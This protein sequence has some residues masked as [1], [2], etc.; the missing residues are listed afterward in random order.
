MYYFSLI[1]TYF[2][3]SF[4]VSSLFLFNKTHLISTLFSPIFTHPCY[5]HSLYFSPLYQTD[6]KS[7][8]FFVQISES[9]IPNLRWMSDKKMEKKGGGNIC[10]SAMEQW[11]MC[12]SHHCKPTPPYSIFHVGHH[13]SWFQ[14]LPLYQCVQLL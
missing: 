13:P 12:L 1:S 4:F 11:L 2:S 10:T 7:Q 6:P 8:R 14:K 9:N 5:F 3:I